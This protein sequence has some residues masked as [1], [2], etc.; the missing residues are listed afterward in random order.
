M[1]SVS[2][3]IDG[4]SVKNRHKI[5]H[6]NVD[7]GRRAIPQDDTLPVPMP[8]ADELD[9][10][11]LEDVVD[12][13]EASD[14]SPRASTDP[15]YVP[16][17]RLEPQT[18]N[19]YE[20]NDLVRDLALSKEKSEILSSRLKEKNLLQKKVLI[21]NYHKG[22]HDLTAIFRRRSTLLLQ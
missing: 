18:F 11:G 4:F 6:P 21:S 13:D 3:N 7:S 17:E 2:V 14:K 10:I 9:S 16:D 15:D 12:G 5:I 19:Q 8:P 20:L 1:Q 22:N